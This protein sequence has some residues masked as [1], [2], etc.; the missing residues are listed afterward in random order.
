M[1]LFAGYINIRQ[2]RVWFARAIVIHRP[3]AIAYGDC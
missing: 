3:E 1:L 2:T